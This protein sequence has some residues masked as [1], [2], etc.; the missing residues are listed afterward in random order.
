MCQ[1]VD[2]FSGYGIWSPQNA[3]GGGLQDPSNHSR[4]SFIFAQQ[5]LGDAFIPVLPPTQA[6]D[7]LDVSQ[8]TDKRKRIASC[9]RAPNAHSRALSQQANFTSLEDSGKYAFRISAFNL[10]LAHP[11]QV[12]AVLFGMDNC[13]GVSRRSIC[14]SPLEAST[15]PRKY[16]Q[17]TLLVVRGK[18]EG[19]MSRNIT[20][21]VVTGQGITGE[22]RIEL[23][24]EV[25]EGRDMPDSSSVIAIISFGGLHYGTVAAPRQSDSDFMPDRHV[26]ISQSHWAQYYQG[27]RSLGAFQD[28]F[29]R[30][31]SGRGRGIVR[32]ISFV[33]EVLSTIHLDPPLPAEIQTAAG[34][35]FE[36]LQY[37]VFTAELGDESGEGHIQLHGGPLAPQRLSAV[38]TFSSSALFQ[39]Q[40]PSVCDT[41]AGVVAF[42]EATEAYLEAKMTHNSADFVVQGSWENFHVVIGVQAHPAIGRG[43]FTGLEPLSS[44]LVRVRVRHEHVISFGDNSNVYQMKLT[45][46]PPA[47]VASIGL[48]TDLGSSDSMVLT[49]TI[50]GTLD[51]NTPP[52]VTKFMVRCMPEQ[53]LALVPEQTSM[54]LCLSTPLPGVCV[55]VHVCVCVCVCVF[56]IVLHPKGS[57]R[58]RRCANG[59]RSFGTEWPH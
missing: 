35:R 32:R 6:S 46:N 13:S 41:K 22:R 2:C 11:P 58:R 54:M 18:G 48:L 42:C 52:Y 10:Q 9:A 44:F 45:D 57:H 56:V 12:E 51:F 15:Q 33:D 39:W 29:F 55:C 19:L 20:E 24:Q 50:P 47:S 37:R 28:M 8:I 34:D 26:H 21:Y 30:L 23:Q 43:L 49:W 14:L 16:A 53:I 31:D 38:Q 25:P 40:Q 27:Q 4:I 1:C 36:I 17:Q 5:R 59:R 3:A 7:C